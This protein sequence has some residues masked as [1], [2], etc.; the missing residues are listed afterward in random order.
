M[1]QRGIVNEPLT[2][3]E[4]MLDFQFVSDPRR[5][6]FELPG[7]PAGWPQGKPY[8][9]QP[10]TFTPEQARDILKY[11][12]IRLERIPK[13]L[14]HDDMCANR[15]FLLN[16]LRG[17]SRKKGLIAVLRDDGWNHNTPQTAS[18]TREGF[19][20]DGQ[21]RFAASVLANKPI[22][23]PYMSC[24]PW[25][26]FVDID[27]GRGREAAQLVDVPYAEHAAAAARRILPVLKGI[28]RQV[29][30][31]QN[32]VNSDIVELVHGWP[33]FQESW[34]GA[35]GGTWMQEIMATRPSRVP[36][37]P[38]IAS[39]MMALAAGADRFHVLEFLEGLKPSYTRGYDTL[40]T[41]GADPRYLLRDRYL[42]RNKNTKDPKEARRA[43][44]YCRRALAVW[45]EY[46]RGGRVEELRALKA[47]G[48]REL[49]PEV[50]RADAV[51]KFH[52]E[53]VC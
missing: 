14:R 8:A 17:T 16:V 5:A 32:A 18:F 23:L 12:V 2:P 44:A 20:L 52:N 19:L 6:R 11:R 28:E 7:A 35:G 30:A 29:W 13:D 4:K 41:T 42:N 15:K 43:V 21:H 46:K 9:H 45:L 3:I 50:W 47:V 39:V 51:R 53:V 48:E 33:F 10:T 31:E 22:T 37:T 27:S 1:A 34:D 26:T 38:L 24:V 36:L 49:L 25:D 40:G